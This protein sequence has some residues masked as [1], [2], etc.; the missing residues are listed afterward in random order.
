MS[1]EERNKINYIVSLINIFALKYDMPVKDAFLYLSKYKGIQF[2]DKCYDIE[3]TLS[4]N[5]V[6]SDIAVI[7]RNNGGIL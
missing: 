6:V 4:F 5:D 3:H 1:K 7:C 2:I